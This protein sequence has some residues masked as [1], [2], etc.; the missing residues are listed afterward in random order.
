MVVH[1]AMVHPG[2]R[3]DTFSRND[4]KAGAFPRVLGKGVNDAVRAQVQ[5]AVPVDME[6]VKP[7][8]MG[9]DDEL[10][11]LPELGFQQRCVR[12]SLVV[13]PYTLHDQYE[14]LIWQPVARLADD[15]R[16]IQALFGAP[17]AIHAGPDDVVVIVPVARGARRGSPTIEVLSPWRREGAGHP[18]PI[19]IDFVVHTEHMDAHRNVEF[20]DKRQLDLVPFIDFYRRP[21]HR[22]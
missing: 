1:V 14:C 11:A 8:A 17:H 15:E 10:D 19:A 9:D 13:E 2:A 18:R 22:T 7:G 5:P 20:I 4:L 12:V 3:T 21:G 6:G 16:P